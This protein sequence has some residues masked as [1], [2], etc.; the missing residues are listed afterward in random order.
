M[1]RINIILMITTCLLYNTHLTSTR[2]NHNNNHITALPPLPSETETLQFA[3]QRLA[4]V[5]PV[6]Q[7]F[8]SIIT[9]DPFNVTTNW[10]GSDICNYTGFYC[11]N[12]PD[13]QSAIALASI[14]FNGYQLSAPSIEG[15]IDQLPDIALFHANSN[16][17]GGT[18]SPNITKLNYLYELD[19]S[20]NKFSGPFPTAVVGMEG[21]TFLDIR[22]NTFS[23][24]VPPEIFIQNLDA[25]FI[26]NNEF[27]SS[28]PDNL[29]NTHILLLA[30]ANNKF[31]G[32]I[33]PA[34]FKSFSSLTEVLFLNNQLTGCLPYEI[35]YLTEA[36]V[37]DF[38]GNRLTGV[39]PLSLICLEK[40]EELNFADNLLYGVV[41]EL[42]CA[43]G[44]LVNVTLSGNYFTHVGPLCRLLIHKG[45]V[46]VRNNCIGG[47]P[48]Q[49][50]VIEC[51]KFFIRPKGCHRIWHYGYIPC[52]P[53]VPALAPSP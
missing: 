29:G 3:D 23:G 20:N 6:I 4:A 13:N 12:P 2:S 47:L 52:L 37:V 11:S 16:K 45:V 42:L 30:L 18:V 53:F 50:S 51:A 1:R 24:S 35:G 17:F 49:R 22:F 41:P 31:T 9:S 26:N 21:L 7:S 44:N 43:L 32:P 14:D 27:M 46:N 33:P 19:L 38:G 10:V 15:F 39:L 34:I 28:L 40:L 5:Y 48:F 8:K 25:L 36:K